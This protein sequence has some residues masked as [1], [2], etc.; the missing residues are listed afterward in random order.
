MQLLQLYYCNL[1]WIVGKDK[2]SIVLDDWVMKRRE[3]IL[4]IEGGG[5]KTTWCLVD[6]SENILAQGKVG[7]GNV[8]L[9]SDAELRELFL[10][11][12]EALPTL[13]NRV[14]AGM[15]GVMKFS[16][17]GRVKRVLK[18]V[19]SQAKRIEVREDSDSGFYAAHGAKPGV[20]VIA[21]TGSN[22]MVSDGKRQIKLGGWGQYAGDWGS[23]W[24]IAQL[25]IQSAFSNYDQTG[26]FGK[27]AKALFKETGTDTMGDLAFCSLQLAQKKADFSSLVKAVFRA[28][29][30]GDLEAKRCINEGLEALSQRVA[31]GMKRLR[32]KKCDIA[33]IGGM[34]EHEK[35]YR[36]LFYK[37]LKEK[38]LVQSFFLCEIPGSLGA[39]RFN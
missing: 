2:G 6:E 25:G 22:V 16:E 5:T 30:Q 33:V 19:F 13:P 21:G 15:A 10:E 4:G 17:G 29:K 34:F 18:K 39:T 37:L 9:L 8:S 31:W 32:L 24:H 36:D 14:G 11:I 20:L 28:T 35:A 27:L 1:I 38:K 26:K 3:L 12:A 23:A 7:P